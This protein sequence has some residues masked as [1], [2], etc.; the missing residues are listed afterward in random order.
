[1][2]LG[3]GNTEVPLINPPSLTESTSS[4]LSMSSAK[5]FFGCANF[6]IICVTRG[7]GAS[8]ISFILLGKT[9]M[10]GAVI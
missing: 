8:R 9:V 10:Y 2:Y 5:I 3:Y 1:M 6:G 7:T 4:F